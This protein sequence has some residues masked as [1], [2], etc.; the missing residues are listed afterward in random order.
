[1]ILSLIGLG[2][3]AFS[4]YNTY[5]QGQAQA[6]AL[7]EQANL[8]SNRANEFLRRTEKNI[9]ARRKQFQQAIGGQKAALATAG[10]DIGSGVSLD[11]MEDAYQS[12]FEEEQLVME[13]AE[14]QAMSIE[15]G[16]T[17]L[18]KQASD[19]STAGTI[20]AVTSLLGSGIK[21]FKATK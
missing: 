1:M 16:A 17:A 8:D 19:V 18:K 21:Y 4:A 2:L 10:I 13:E 11:M 3:G 5:Q 12:L 15:S 7:S 14:Y 9:A 6:A 20:G